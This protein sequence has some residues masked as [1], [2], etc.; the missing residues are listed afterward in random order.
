MA[1]LNLIPIAVAVPLIMLIVVLMPALPLAWVGIAVTRTAQGVRRGEGR[2][3]TARIIARYIAMSVVLPCV[4]VLTLSLMIIAQLVLAPLTLYRH[5]RNLYETVLWL[6]LRLDPMTHPIDALAAPPKPDTAGTD[7]PQDA[8]SLPHYTFTSLPPNHIRILCIHPGAHNTPLCGSIITTPLSSA[9]KYDALSYAQ[10]TTPVDGAD[11]SNTEETRREPLLCLD[12]TSSSQTPVWA[13]LR[14]TADCAAALRRVRSEG[15]KTRRLWLDAVC[16]NQDNPVEKSVQV[17][18]RDKIL[19]AARRVVVY[20]GEGDEGTD[21]VLDWVN[22]LPSSSLE[23]GEMELMSLRGGDLSLLGERQGRDE[24]VGVM[25][26]GMP[27]RTRERMERLATQLAEAWR[28][29]GVDVWRLA[30]QRYRSSVAALGLDPAAPSAPRPAP[31]NLLGVLEAY[32]SRR[33]FW[34]VWSLQELAVPDLP[35]ITFICG[36]R[37]VTGQ[38]MLHLMRLL[39]DARVSKNSD[40]AKAVGLFLQLRANAGPRRPQLLDLLIQTRNHQCEDP[41]E[42][43]YGILSIAMLLHGSSS[44]SAGLLA[45]IDHRVSVSGIYAALSAQLIKQYGPGFFLALIKSPQR[46]SGLPSWAAD[47]TAPWPNARA[48]A[49]MDCGAQ[50]RFANEK[51]CVLGFQTEQTTDR[52]IMKIMRPRIVRGFFTRDGHLD[53]V[54]RT[55]IENVR[56]LNKDE[57]LVEIFP[58]LALLLKRERGES[59]KYT[60][61]RACPHALSRDGLERIVASWSRV[62]VF[63][64]EI[65]RQDLEGSASKA[66][67]SLP[68]VY[69]IV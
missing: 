3:C 21:Q 59:E 54:A 42:R 39:K 51:D 50:P 45:N 43:V 31:E 65:G 7:I 9:P 61:I 20:T 11:N 14:I 38:R 18:M 26:S 25:W 29:Y 8:S 67:L 35:R 15:G 36:T 49:F 55:R 22:S 34:R 64:E 5:V 27:V 44:T 13:A 4:A 1:G 10:D 48:L 24:V 69:E 47:W 56:Q 37:E 52:T 32:F 23:H 16:I 57:D 66:Y 41:R 17:G 68:R 19:C 28:R 53:G 62:V 46:V 63:Q 40:T 2:G 6:S 12:H 58:G 60:F 33:W 30:E